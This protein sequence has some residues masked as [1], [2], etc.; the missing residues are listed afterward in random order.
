MGIPNLTQTITTMKKLF[1]FLSIIIS[2]SAFSQEY[3]PYKIKSGK[4]KYQVIRYKTHSKEWT[5]KQG[6]FQVKS[7]QIPFV[8]E[9]IDY[10]W[11][12]YG[13]RARAIAYKVA[14]L[15]GNKLSA[16]VKDYEE[17]W[18][19]K[20]HLFYQNNNVIIDSAQTRIAC[21]NQPEK[22]KKYGWFKLMHPSAEKIGYDTI[23]GEP[24]VVF[25]TDKFSDHSLWKGVILQDVSYYADGKGVRT[26]I[27][28]KKRAVELN[29]LPKDEKDIFTPVWYQKEMNYLALNLSKIISILNENTN[30]L[31]LIGDTGMRPSSG[32]VILFT[33]DSSNYGKFKVKKIDT[34][35]GVMHFEFVVYNSSGSVVKQ[36]KLEVLRNGNSYNLTKAMTK[37]SDNS[38]KDFIWKNNRLFSAN[39]QNKFYWLK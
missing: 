13:N 38:I 28:L 14:D 26:G 11:D 39:T 17:L 23:I 25:R 4:I 24:A 3:R 6:G 15:N 18:I 33:I 12:D 1:F 34:L 22:L 2:F 36:K 20:K 7:E 5:G 31:L 37:G 9:T 16:P 8:S 21:L 10:Y 27:N 30:N 32:D 35:Y 29:S 19:G